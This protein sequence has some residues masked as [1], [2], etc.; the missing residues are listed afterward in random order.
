MNM[1]RAASLD[2]YES[3][4]TDDGGGTGNEEKELDRSYRIREPITPKDL[5]TANRY[6]KIMSWNVSSLKSLATTNKSKLRELIRNQTPDI[7]LLQA[8]SFAVIANINV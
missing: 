1:K 6:I 3:N 8:R 5:D 7:L 4:A 2:G